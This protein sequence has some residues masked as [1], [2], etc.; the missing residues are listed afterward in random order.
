M[1]LCLLL[2]FSFLF[3][4]ISFAQTKNRGNLKPLF[5]QA[6]KNNLQ[7]LPQRFEYSLWDQERFSVGDILIDS[8]QLTFNLEPSIQKKNSY[9]IRFT[10]PAGLIR[11]GQ[12]TIKDNSGKAIFLTELDKNSVKISRGTPME[13]REALRS[14]IASYIAD[15]VPSDVIETMKY[16]PFMVFCVYNETDSTRFYLCSKELYITSQD[17]HAIIK[18][19]NAANKKAQVDVNG[20]RVGD[21][22]VIYLNDEQEFVKFKAITQSG[23]SLEIETRRNN[24]DFKDVVENGDKIILTAS[25]AEPTD[26]KIFKR[27]SASEWQATLTKERPLIYLRGESDI[28]LRQEFNI[29]GPLPQ[30]KLRPY[31]SAKSISK[32][33]A[34]SINLPVLS[35]QGGSLKKETSDAS[36]QLEGLTKNQYRWTLNDIADGEERHFLNVTSG[37]DTFVVGYDTNKGNPY[38]AYLGGRY[39]LPSGLIFA[40]AQIQWWIE[41]FLFIPSTEAHLKWGVSLVQDQ[42]INSKSDYPKIDITTVELLWRAK[43]GFNMVDETWGLLLPLQ[44]LRGEGSSATQYGLGAFWQGLPHQKRWYRFMEWSDVKLQYFF[45]SSGSD[46]KVKSA[47]KMDAGAYKKWNEKY[48]WLFRYG[49]SLSQY[50][51]TPSAP[52]EDIQL[53]FN[54]GVTWK[55]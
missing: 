40:S 3:S 35:P 32:T 2:A 15:S 46:F 45:G 16:L 25:G 22:G 18:S 47:W 50:T 55:F 43:A 13:G 52:K 34:S 29:Q 26:E 44:I 7:V 49:V 8:T 54:A 21:Q 1:K 12:L 42:H 10:W 51:Y 39:E 23:S 20:A 41:N 31:T 6:N 30:E 17:G 53:D 33:Y 5:F 38:M 24:V 36:S 14:D 9:N 11:N 28:P 48:S 4:Q 27:I 37:K 19:R